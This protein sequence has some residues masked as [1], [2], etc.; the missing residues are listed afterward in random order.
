MMRVTITVID[1]EAWGRPLQKSLTI[2]LPVSHRFIQI[3]NSKIRGLVLKEYPGYTQINP[4]KPPFSV[5]VWMTEKINFIL[6]W[7]T[8]THTLSV[9]YQD[10]LKNILCLFFD[11]NRESKTIISNGKS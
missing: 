7:V 9:C 10:A 5:F 6:I 8:K 11:G 4:F 2:L 3:I 1:Q